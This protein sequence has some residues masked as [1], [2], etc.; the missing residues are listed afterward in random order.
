MGWG[1]STSG[2]SGGVSKDGMLYFTIISPRLERD[3][4]RYAHR[5]AHFRFDEGSRLC[6]LG[7]LA[8]LVRGVILGTPR[9]NFCGTRLLPL[10][11]EAF[12]ILE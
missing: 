11:H 9:P 2:M 4:R 12:D 1:A 3:Y 5:R 7:P 6:P 10:L 8:F